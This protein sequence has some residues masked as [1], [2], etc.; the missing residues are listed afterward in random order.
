MGNGKMNIGNEEWE[1]GNG[2]LE[3]GEM[4]IGNEEWEMKNG[5]MG[6]G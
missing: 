4:D 5:E 6:N 3:I 1:M 2:K